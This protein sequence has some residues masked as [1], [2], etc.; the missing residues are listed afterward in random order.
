MHILNLDIFT[1]LK[2]KILYSLDTQF[3]SL[4]K[5]WYFVRVYVTNNYRMIPSIIAII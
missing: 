2:I 4:K 3:S 5:S 1:V